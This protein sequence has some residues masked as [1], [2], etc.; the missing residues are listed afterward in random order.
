MQNY[1]FLDALAQIARDSNIAED[2]LLEALANALLA[3][4]KRL[5][6][7]AEDAEVT[8]DRESGEIKV[9]GLELDLEGNVTREWD[10]TPNDFGR[11]AAQTAKQVLLQII[12]DIQRKQM[13][14]EYAGR[15][16]DIVTGIVQQTD[17]RYT[18]LDLGKVEALLPQA[19]Q[20]AY[21]RYD[22]GARVKAYIVEVRKTTKGP[23]IV[24]SRTHP[25]LVKRL[26]ELEVPEIASGIVE[27]KALAREPGHRTKIAVWSNDHNVDPVGACVGARGSR[28]RMV[29]N[30]LKSERVDVVP[31]SE[32]PVDFIQSALQPAR[33]REVRLDEE[34]NATVI[35]NDAQ[36]SLAIGKEGQNARLA[37]RL[38]GWRIDIRSETQD[39]EEAE[40][41]YAAGEWVEENGQMVWHPAPEED[42]GAAATTDAAASTSSSD[43]PGEVAEPEASSPEVPAPEVPAPP[44]EAPSDADLAAE[45]LVTDDA[46]VVSEGTTA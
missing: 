2:E 13:Y 28:V 9:F 36:L 32:D 18:L 1:E 27:I 26:F 4:Y 12:R 41:E 42:S 15:E 35:V 21:E 7:S 10:A 20:I 44:V 39:A 46:A 19:E 34:G 22:H 29:T 43:A 8:I 45:V 37:A 24:V 30:E 25:G 14:D 11:I 17:S 40:I 23:Q 38:T 6:D 5:P 3:A 31:F 16:G 33:V